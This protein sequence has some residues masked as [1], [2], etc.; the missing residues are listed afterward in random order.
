MSKAL[1]RWLAIQIEMVSRR[2]G[3]SDPED[4]SLT[5]DHGPILWFGSRQ[6]DDYPAGQDMWQTAIE[7]FGRQI[8]WFEEPI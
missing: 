2:W 5:V 6:F 3:V 4:G 1:K 8:F 7:I